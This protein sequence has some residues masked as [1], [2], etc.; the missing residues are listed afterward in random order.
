M[1]FI[2]NSQQY[3]ELDTK[4]F[5]VKSLLYI[6]NICPPIS[7]LIKYKEIKH[8]AFWLSRDAMIISLKKKPLKTKTIESVLQNRYLNKTKLGE[9]KLCSTTKHICYKEHGDKKAM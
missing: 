4:G 8:K 9:K 3:K 5:L 6:W 1:L 2:Y 7:R